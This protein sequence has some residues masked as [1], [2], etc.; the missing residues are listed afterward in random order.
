[1]CKKE[2]AL[3]HRKYLVSFLTASS[4]ASIVEYM[5][6]HFSLKIL[7][8][9]IKSFVETPVYLPKKIWYCVNFISSD[10]VAYV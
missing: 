6:L 5:F 9:G 7:S 3:H 2:T 10:H 1:M 4:K 8:E